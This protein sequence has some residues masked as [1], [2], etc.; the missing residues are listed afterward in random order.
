M[1]G[2]EA[3]VAGGKFS[4]TSIEIL[5]LLLGLLLVFFL[6][7]EGSMWLSAVS[8]SFLS[9]LLE[10]FPFIILGSLVSG[11]LE[12]F[13][14]PGLFRRILPKNRF[15][16][17]V[18]CS[19]LGLLFPICECGVVP[20]VRRLIRKGVP[21]GCAITY[22]LAAPII[23]VIVAG[24]T[25]VAFK[26]DMQIVGLRL[27]LGFIVATL[28]GLFFIYV[29][30][31][32]NAI[33]KDGA[34]DDATDDHDHDH[35]ESC[36]AAGCDHDHGAG[37]AKVSLMGRLGQ[38]LQVARH[39][40]FLMGRWLIWGS[41]I[42]ALIQAS[43]PRDSLVEWGSGQIGGSITMI[44]MAIVLSLCSEADAFVASSFTTFSLWGK[45]SF[46]VL[47]PM[48]DI[49]LFAMYFE[50]FKKRTILTI[51]VSTVVLVFLATAIVGPELGKWVGSPAVPATGAA[52][53][54]AEPGPPA[55]ATLPTTTQPTPA[56]TTQT[57]PSSAGS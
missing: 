53:Q 25:M 55:P 38:S 3:G 30:E 24:S 35:G 46:L 51:A 23:N 33:I 13:V 34:L 9:I 11:L 20:I 4:V 10:A 44:V 40:F 48:F 21:A 39:D 26:F 57:A 43:V 49:K 15:K 28:I 27:L 22:M 29:M 56:G 50:I 18:S 8:T 16:A 5:L 42:A 52:A 2:S 6:G 17:V 14:P 31:P 41:L 54:P 1:P 32:R 47:G 19:L 37:G 12:V 7:A 36:C 45:L